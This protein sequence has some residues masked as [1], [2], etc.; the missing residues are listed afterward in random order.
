MTSSRNQELEADFQSL[1]L[2]KRS[3]Y[4]P[5]SM[6][7]TISL[8]PESIDY[9]YE[10]LSMAMEQI[11]THPRIQTRVLNLQNRVFGFEHDFAK[12]FSVIS[13]E[14][15]EEEEEEIKNDNMYDFSILSFFC[16]LFGM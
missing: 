4:D 10:I 7:K 1:Y 9:D 15:M 16:T 3:G 5:S 6:I 14:E 11:D 2:L 12:R 8:L 13:E